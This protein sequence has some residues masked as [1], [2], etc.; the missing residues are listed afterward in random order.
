[1]IWHVFITLALALPTGHCVA[2]QNDRIYARDA[3]SAI[4]EFS[5]LPGD[6]TIGFAPA[7][8]ARRILTSAALVAIAKSEG[9]ELQSPRN[10]CFEL[11]S[12][13]L[14]REDVR[15]AILDEISRESH[16]CD[17]G[18][19]VI[20]EVL[21]WGPETTPPGPIVFPNGCLQLLPNHGSRGEALWRGYILYGTNRRFEV[22]ARARIT[23]H[24]TEVVAVS[25]I[26]MG[27][28]IRRDQV[29]LV[30]TEA[31]FLDDKQASRLEE[32]EGYASRKPVH[33]GTAIGRNQL[34]RLPEVGK[35][36]IVQVQVVAG[37]ARLALE[38]RA[39][40][41]GAIG[42][43]VWVKNPTSGKTFR[44]KVLRKGTVAVTTMAGG[45]REE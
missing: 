22:W 20:V 43:L 40:S 24:A 35:G 39:E 27:T 2:V 21:Q 26:N 17:V 30:R 13:E 38:G 1:M 5:A 8:G 18:D 45:I 9:V 6:M 16:K 42:A 34:Y 36:D 19:G 32:V 41:A 29:R 3:V 23:I 4:P 25:D 44:A 15:T 11:R 37:S 33:A 12:M 31:S 7:P 28:P 10:V 14:R